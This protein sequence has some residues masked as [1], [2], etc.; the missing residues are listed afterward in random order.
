MKK[1]NPSKRVNRKTFF[2]TI[3]KFECLECLLCFVS[4]LVDPAVGVFLMFGW[5][6]RSKRLKCFE[7][8]HWVSTLFYKSFCSSLR[9]KFSNRRL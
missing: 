7:Q 6:N 9:K 8:E 2:G 5:Q 1:V 4:W 3:F